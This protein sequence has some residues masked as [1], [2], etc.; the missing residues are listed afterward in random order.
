M[1]NTNQKILEIAKLAPASKMYCTQINQSLSLHTIRQLKMMRMIVKHLNLVVSYLK[2]M[3]W[4]C[5]REVYGGSSEGFLSGGYF[6]IDK[7]IP[8]LIC[9]LKRLCFHLSSL[10]KPHLLLQ[11]SL[12]NL[13]FRFATLAQNCFQ[14]MGIITFVLAYSHLCDTACRNC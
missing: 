11:V 10:M 9:Y 7:M 12:S 1:T 5:L 2:P 4:A 13:S 3:N 14:V 8:W 6:K